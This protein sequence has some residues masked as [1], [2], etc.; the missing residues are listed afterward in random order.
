MVQAAAPPVEE[1]GEHCPAARNLPDPFHLHPAVDGQRN[2]GAEDA[3]FGLPEIGRGMVAFTGGVQRLTQTLPHAAAIEVILTGGINP[4]GRL[5][6]PG[7]VNRVVPRGQALAEAL[8]LADTVVASG[9]SAFAAARART[10]GGLPH[11]LPFAGR[12]GGRG[13][14]QGGGCRETVSARGP[15]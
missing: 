12:D 8:A 1:S 5:K 13:A 4:A 2:P 3:P 6:A 9:L 7:L 11:L 10:T 15:I 14:R